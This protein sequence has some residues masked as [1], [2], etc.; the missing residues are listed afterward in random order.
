MISQDLSGKTAALSARSEQD[1]ACAW[2]GTDCAASGARPRFAIKDGFPVLVVE[3]AQ[4]PAGCESLSQLPCQR[5][6]TKETSPH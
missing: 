2:R 6:E 3:E 4:S 5:K 1:A